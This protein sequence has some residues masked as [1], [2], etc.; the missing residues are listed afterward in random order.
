MAKYSVEVQEAQISNGGL[1]IREGWILVYHAN[2][3]TRE[4]TGVTNEYLLIDTGLPANGYIDEPTLP[5]ED[6]KAVI[7]SK[8]G[9]SWEIVSDLRGK[10][11]YDTSTLQSLIINFL[12]DLPDNLTLLA[13][14]TPY[15]KWSGTAWVTDKDAEHAAQIAQAEQQKAALLNEAE[16]MIARLER[17]VKA[18]LA[19]DEQKAALDTW[20]KYAV[21]VDQVDTSKAPD[22][23][24]P[25]K[26]S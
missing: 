25:V 2:A 10:T 13:P 21:L 11:A 12:G 17:A 9:Q 1:A 6:D 16:T 14:A 4:Y 19:T 7:R 15:D 20:N 22:I 26:P 24:W 3:I 18:G 5:T 8:D 23:T